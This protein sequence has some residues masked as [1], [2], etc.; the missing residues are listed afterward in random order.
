MLVLFQGSLLSLS[1][2]SE[3]GKR[4]PLLLNSIRTAGW[5]IFD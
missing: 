3:P 5:R 4:I 1:F 2:P